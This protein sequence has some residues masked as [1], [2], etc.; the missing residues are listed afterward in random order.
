MLLPLKAVVS[1][2]VRKDG[3][4]VIYYQYCFSSTHRVLLN[5]DIAIPKAC[6]NSK[7]QCISKSLPTDLGGFED[8]NAELGRIRKVIETIIEHGLSK[9]DRN[10]GA[11]VKEVFKPDFKV[12]TLQSTRIATY[13]RKKEPDFF[14][15]ID[16]YIL[17][18]EKKVCEEGVANFRTMKHRLMAFEEFRKRK[19]AFSS[20]DYNFYHQFVDFLTHDFLHKRKLIPEYGLKIS[21]IGRTIKQLRIFV[22]D[23]VRRKAVAPIDMDDFKILDE[24][25]D[26][27]YLTY[28]EIGKIYALD[29]ANDPVLALHRDMFVLGCLTGLRFSDYSTLRGS[30]LRNGLL[31]KKTSK[32]DSWVVIPLRSEAIAIFERHYAT[33]V[34]AISNSVFNKCI[35][36]IGEL[37]DIKDMITFSYKKGNKDIS[38]AKPK[39]Q[40]IT[41]HTC[42][43]SF[44]TNEYLSGEVDI[45]LIMKISGHKTHK[46]FFKYIRVTQEEAAYKIQAIWQMRNNMAAFPLPKTA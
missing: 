34:P 15:E 25:T 2:K 42:R 29:L 37:A 4:S 35:K 10:I 32:T 23:R 46:E 20:L 43:R 21:T 14:S 16:D 13:V 30:D 6:W 44:C 3:K 17:S 39:A 1:T 33:G 36:E 31:Y 24:E 38:V 18:K 45:S 41:S 8:L 22:K 12:D 11:Y 26:A 40:W 28:E 27:I 7:R 5:T 19:I 9:G